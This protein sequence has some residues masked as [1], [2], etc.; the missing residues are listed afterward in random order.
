MNKNI[1]VRVDIFP[2]GD[3][4]PIEI[5]KNNGQS[6]I[7]NRVI[8]IKKNMINGVLSIDFIC[9]THNKVIILRKTNDSWELQ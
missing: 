1:I 9:K 6:I 8:N 2:N 4:C 7:I 3:I 5:T